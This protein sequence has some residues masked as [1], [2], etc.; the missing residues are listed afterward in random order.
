MLGAAV[1]LCAALAAAWLLAACSSNP[2]H[3]GTPDSRLGENCYRTSTRGPMTRVVNYA[4]PELCERPVAHRGPYHVRT[5]PMPK[6]GET[7]GR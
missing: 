7:R 3:Q 2:W 5:R 1:A 4:D 6:A